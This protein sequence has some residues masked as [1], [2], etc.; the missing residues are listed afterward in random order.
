MDKSIAG[1]IFD[2]FVLQE[3]LETSLGTC[4]VPFTGLRSCKQQKK[5]HDSLLLLVEWLLSCLAH[6]I[7]Q[8]YSG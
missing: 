2:A 1:G 3:R 5:R 4:K 8:G 7:A 6:P